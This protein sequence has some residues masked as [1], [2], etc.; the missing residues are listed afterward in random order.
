MRFFCTFFPEIFPHH[1]I[2]LDEWQSANYYVVFEYSTFTTA[3]K[4]SLFRLTYSGHVTAEMLNSPSGGVNEDEENSIKNK[5]T[6]IY[7]IL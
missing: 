4:L 7:S 3:Q 2:K 1:Q 6:F 5:L